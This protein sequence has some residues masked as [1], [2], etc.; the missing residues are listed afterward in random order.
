MHTAGL[1]WSPPA[2]SGISRGGLV[3]PLRRLDRRYRERGLSPANIFIAVDVLTERAWYNQ[4]IRSV[5]R[6]V[7]GPFLNASTLT[8]VTAPGRS[9]DGPPARLALRAQSF[10]TSDVPHLL[11]SVSAPRDHP[12]ESFL[13]HEDF[14]QLALDSLEGDEQLD[15]LRAH[16]NGLWVFA[17]PVIMHRPDGTERHVRAVWY[18]Q[19][20]VVW[21]MRTFAA[22]RGN[23]AR[24][25]GDRLSG[26]LPF[27]PVW[28]ETRPEQ[29]LLAAVWALMAQ[30]GVTE[31]ERQLGSSG[32]SDEDRAIDL[33]SHLRRTRG[34]G[35]SRAWFA[36]AI[37]ASGLPPLTPHD[38]R[39]TAASLAISSGANVR[40]VQRMLGH[41]SAKMTLDTY[42][43]LF[44]DD[45]DHVAGRMDEGLRSTIVGRMWAEE[46]A[47]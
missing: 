36:R 38:L 16:I 35:S 7:T 18:R 39:H 3:E 20:E 15:P 4:S 19:G 37:A 33:G 47:S 17:R 32:T 1:K 44:D 41:A 46:A 45:L 43:D 40:A 12:E 14:L 25:V 5:R 2:G 8:E 21:R 28:D 13:L 42:A 10:A 24:E 11:R 23:D 9:L 22:G 29:K 6:N 27:V 30:G 34:G 31:S 26:R